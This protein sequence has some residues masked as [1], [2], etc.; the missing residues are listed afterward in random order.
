[1]PRTGSSA[2]SRWPA[3]AAR[4]RLRR[5]RAEPAVEEH[6]D[7]AG[8][9][10]DHHVRPARPAEPGD[11]RTEEVR[12]RGVPPP[13]LR[14]LAPRGA[15]VAVAVVPLGGEQHVVGALVH[16]GGVLHGVVA[17]QQH[18]AVLAGRHREAVGRQQHHP[19]R[20]RQALGLVEQVEPAVALGEDRRVDDSGRGQVGGPVEELVRGRQ[21]AGGGRADQRERRP[22]SE[23]AGRGRRGGRADAPGARR[24]TGDQGGVVEHPAAV[25]DALEVRRPQLTGDRPGGQRGERAG[26][27][28]PRPAGAA[29]AHP[30]HDRPGADREVAVVVLD[31][32]RVGEVP[33]PDQRRGSVRVRQASRPPTAP[34]GRHRAARAAGSRRV[35]IGEARG[36][37]NPVAP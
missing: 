25:A 36:K 23:R 6:P 30:R 24:E 29:R 9:P 34:P 20:R 7:P 14:G 19:D 1:M 28:A 18:L 17:A 13:L 35:P 10:R 37:A 2:A 15:V 27:V 33:L 21:G 4:A 22:R 11:L 31:H 3:E 32:A 8:A 12:R 16:E 5:G 26:Q